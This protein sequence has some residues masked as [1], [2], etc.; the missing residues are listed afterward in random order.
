M[1]TF[2]E[3]QQREEADGGGGGGGGGGA[4]GA[5]TGPPFPRRKH[6]FR[7]V[8]PAGVVE[9]ALSSP[10]HPPNTSTSTTSL[11]AGGSGGSNG[12]R[13]SRSTTLPGD[14]AAAAGAAGAADGAEARKGSWRTSSAWSPGSCASAAM[15]GGP[16]KAAARQ[17]VWVLAATNAKVSDVAVLVLCG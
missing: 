13:S 15:E 8:A 16:G 17:Q 1:E 6:A 14:A 7:L 4:A 10:L 3:A 12:A 2:E 11:P 5:A 9:D